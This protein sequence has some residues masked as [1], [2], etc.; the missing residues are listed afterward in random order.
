MAGLRWTYDQL[1]QY[2]EQQR[3]EFTGSLNPMIRNFLLTCPYSS[4][5]GL[6]GHSVVLYISPGVAAKVSLR[7]G[8]DRLRH[9]QHMF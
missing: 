2:L 6:G 4:V 7:A 9:E 1:V 8:D 3:P 5:F